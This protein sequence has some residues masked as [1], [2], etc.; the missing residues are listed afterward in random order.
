MA[1]SHIKSDTIGDFTGTITGFNSQGSTAT[2]AAT[3]LVRPS[4]WNSAHNQF[5]T[6]TGNTLGNST[7][8]GTNVIFAASGGLSIGGSTGSIIFSGP[9]NITFSGYNP[10]PDAPYVAGQVGQGTLALDPAIFPDVQF[11]RLYFPI[12]NTNATN[13]SGSHT[14]SFWIGI[15]TRNASTLSLSL[16]ASGS[17]AATHSGTVGS[18]AS[19]SGNRI[20]SIPFTT[21]LTEGNYWI[22]FLSRTTSGG[23]NGTYSNWQVSNIASAFHGY[24]GSAHTTTQQLTLGQGVYSVTTAGIPSTIG[25]AEI[26]GSDAGALRATPIFFGSGTV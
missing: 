22:G 23:A 14:L 13:S 7:A 12:H 17:T 3:N 8:S 24:F 19:Y 21:T 2:I 15:Y 25:F 5:Y 26:R 4:D 9:P 20:F 11:D 16:S 1:V 10:Y 6:L 18:Y